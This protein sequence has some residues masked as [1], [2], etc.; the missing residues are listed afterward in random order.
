MR[1]AVA[2]LLAIG[3]VVTVAVPALG[4]AP[5]KKVKVEDFKFS[6]KVLHIRRGTKVTWTWVAHSGIAHNV[7]VRRGPA[8]F[9]SRTQSSGSYSHVFRKKG[10][11]KL[12]CTIHVAL[13]MKITVKVS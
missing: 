4:S 7:T 12:I 10:T 8:K 5:V 1:K 13:G 2:L 9:H 3:I 11:Y 6:P